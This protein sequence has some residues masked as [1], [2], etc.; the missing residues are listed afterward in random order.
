M[1]VENA[2]RLDLE[3]DDYFVNCSACGYAET[4]DSH[5]EAD[6]LKDL[7][8]SRMMTVDPCEGP[9]VVGWARK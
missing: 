7:H 2:G 8:T 5:I 9:A 3:S 1:G 6:Y 4:A